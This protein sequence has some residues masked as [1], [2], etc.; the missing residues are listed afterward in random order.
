MNFVEFFVECSMMR[1]DLI[2]QDLSLDEVE[3][4]V[5]KSSGETLIVAMQ[6][7]EVKAFFKMK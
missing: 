3:L 6:D 5:L 2:S 1:K 7:D 4:H